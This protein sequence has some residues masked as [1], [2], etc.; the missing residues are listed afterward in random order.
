MR[1]LVRGL[2]GIPLYLIAFAAAATQELFSY[3]PTPLAAQLTVYIL[4][5]AG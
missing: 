5:N 4:L 1:P 2:I 3:P